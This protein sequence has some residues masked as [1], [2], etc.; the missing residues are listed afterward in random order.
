ML[1][2]VTPD[3][4]DRHGTIEQ[5]AEVKN[6]ILRLAKFAIVDPADYTWGNSE[7]GKTATFEL[8]QFEPALRRRD[9]YARG[10]QL[11]RRG[12]H[13]PAIDIR[14]VRSLRGSPNWQNACA[15]FAALSELRV[16]D[17]DI[18]KGMQSFP[19]LVHR[20]EEL[21]H[22]GKVVI[23]N[24]SKGTNADSTDKALSSFAD[25]IYWIAGGVPKEGGIEPLSAHLQSG[26]LK[27]AYLIGK[28]APEFAET[29]KRYGVPYEISGTLDVALQHAVR[30]AA[31]STAIEPVVLLSPACASYDQ[32]KSFEQRGDHFRTLAAALPGFTKK[33][34]A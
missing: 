6:A 25:D 24:D 27:R 14:A 12:S 9:Y 29:L 10:G 21:G 30:D 20:L 32:Y 1:L 19:G 8:D 28:C 23:V 22:V 17:A 26:K 7:I 15:A 11:Y 13:Q 4:L 31:A 18:Q 5:Y 3:H 16:A 34:Q 2:N 33:A